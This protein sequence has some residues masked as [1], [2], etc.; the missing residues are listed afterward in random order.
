MAANQERYTDFVVAVKRLLRAE[1]GDK[2][3]HPAQVR[4]AIDQVNAS[5]NQ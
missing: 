1:H 4:T 2:S 5:L 3:L